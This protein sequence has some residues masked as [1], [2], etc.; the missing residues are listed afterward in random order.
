MAGSTT[1]AGPRIVMISYPVP[2]RAVP[3]AG[4][5]YLL[6]LCEVLARG[7]T[8]TLLA[9]NTEVNKTARDRPGAP[10]RTLLVG[11]EFGTS[12]AARALAR[13]T[14]TADRW[15]RRIDPGVPYLPFA[16]GL[17][18][19]REARASLR[20]ADVVDLQ[21]DDAIRLRWIV[22]LL[23]R[24]ARL[25]G[26][27]HDVQSQ[28]F[29]R[30][31]ERSDRAKFWRRQAAAARHRERRAVAVLDE[32]L[33]F[34]EKDLQLLG[35]PATARVIRPP[36]TGR[37]IGE[38]TNAAAGEPLVLFV[39]NLH[40]AENDDAAQW[41]VGEIWPVVRSTVPNAR[42]VV[43]G[44]GASTLLRDLVGRTSG[45]DLLGFVDDLEPLYAAARVVVVPLRFGAGVKF[46][47]IE[48]LVRDVP[49]VTT[50]VGAEGIA[51]GPQDA[52]ATFA[53]ITDDAAGLAAGVC[54][55][56]EHTEGARHRAAA[57]GHW[58]RATFG[59]ERFEATVR[60]VYRLGQGTFGA[61]GDRAKG[62]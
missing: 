43:A 62:E 50:T 48:A 53:T 27:F 46:K 26:T 22:R 60:E 38:A 42:L 56:L 41:L 12:L 15:W 29:S 57:A 54:S 61:D 21:W 14:V 16:L 19:S 24:R 13:G 30:E 18:L 58:A 40:R 55:V 39:S 32:V 44:A 51:E 11:R 20:Q 28:S 47:T 9:A 3:H 37:R 59:P 8:F 5:Q 33:A 7:S 25:V 34:S 49:V 36:I 10:E 23:N 52:D 2:H 31:A 1:V 4:G 35:S 45:V 17:L 6:T